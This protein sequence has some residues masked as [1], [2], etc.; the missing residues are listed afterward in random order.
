MI[1]P[2]EERLRALLE[3]LGVARAH[4]AAR[5]PS[6]WSGIA[7]LYPKLVSSLTLVGPG[8][9]DAGAAAEVA[10]RLLVVQ[11]DR[12]PHAERVRA[13][14][15]RLPGARFLALP[16][17]EI[18]GWT[19]LLAERGDEIASAIEELVRRTDGQDAPRLEASIPREGEVAGLSYRIEGV[20]PP[21]VLLPLWLSPSQWEP[22]VPCLR[23]RHA[24][25]VVGGAFV[26]ATAILESRARSGGYQRMLG[27]VIEE[28]KPVPGETI[29]D[30]GCGTGAIDRW[31][32][33]RTEGRNRI[34]GVDINRHLL[35]E[36]RTLCRRHGLDAIVEFS[37]GSAERLPFADDTVDVAL[38]VTVIEE[39]DADR[40]LAEM[41]RV[42]RRGGRV[43]V[44]AR[45]M[46]L[47][48]V[49]NVPLAG[50]LK[51]KIEAPGIIGFVEPHGCADRTLYTRL[52]RAGLTN[53]RMAPTLVTFDSAEPDIMRGIQ[54]MLLAKLDP[55]EAAAWR[56]AR[57][58][59]ETAG[60]FFITMPHHCAVGTKP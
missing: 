45:A 42:T 22:I 11:G 60:T 18:V 58:S 37:E 16:G 21:L 2:V 55:D 3:H 27:A 23:Q 14:A 26:G 38:S 9:V 8:G 41:V 33:A 54:D 25:I 1:M 49:M 39:V 44:I 5:L 51:T 57:A 19:D 59:A 30:V 31:L 35:G 53:I 34:A 17:Y 40:M 50:A 48:W 29:L 7:T 13:A 24:T 36:A 56:S 46:D 10:A 43:A 12:G 15:A 28:V 52:G 20:G 4:I 47:A 32:A 6:D